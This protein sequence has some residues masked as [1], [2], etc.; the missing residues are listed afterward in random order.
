MSELCA[1]LCGCFAHGKGSSPSCGN[2]HLHPVT[3]R[4]SMRWLFPH[5]PRA[6]ILFSQNESR[7]VSRGLLLINGTVVIKNRK[8]KCE[9]CKIQ[10]SS[11][12]CKIIISFLIITISYLYSLLPC[13]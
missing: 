7:S 11:C 2:Q 9:K 4:K 5:M 8:K 3:L 12:R 13:H 10:K 6:H 1:G